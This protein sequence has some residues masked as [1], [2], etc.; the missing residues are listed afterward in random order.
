[1]NTDQDHLGSL[2]EPGARFGRLVVLRRE[3]LICGS[4]WLV[5]CDCG[6]SKSVAQRS[7]RSGSVKSCG[8]LR[9]EK[10]IQ[11]NATHGRTDTPLYLVWGTMFNRCYRPSH[12]GY[13]N[14][15][16]RGITVCD[17]WKSFENFLADMGERPSP[18]HSLDRIDPNGNYE[19]GNVRW[20][21]KQEQCRNKRNNRTLVID[22]VSKC[23]ADWCDFFGT[24]KKWAYDRIRR[25]WSQEDAVRKA[26]R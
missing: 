26:K 18:T 22:G 17:R 14:Y 15:G 1:M 13:K 16:G 24:N 9:R 6:A 3:S 11:R 4:R 8:C 23:I 19:P 7:L 21:T 5:L 2:I 10:L 20:S 25:G 12:K